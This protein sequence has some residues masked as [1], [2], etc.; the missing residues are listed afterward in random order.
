MSIVVTG[1]VGFIGS[2]AAEASLARDLAVTAFGDLS[3]GQRENFAAVA[4]GGLSERHPFTRAMQHAE[5][6]YCRHADLVIS[7]LPNAIEHLAAR[8]LTLDWYAV[9]SN[10]VGAMTD[11]KSQVPPESHL[12]VLQNA[13]AAGRFVVL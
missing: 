4:G 13:R 9:A 1:G 8:G 7:V 2:H 6:Y 11:R 10:G 12:A 3:S 5:D